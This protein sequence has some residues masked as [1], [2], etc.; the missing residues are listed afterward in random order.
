[1]TGARGLGTFPCFL[2]VQTEESS[3]GQRPAHSAQPEAGPEQLGLGPEG[4]G[5]A[6]QHPGLGAGAGL[7]G[8]SPGPGQSGLTGP[9]PG[10]EQGSISPLGSTAQCANVSAVL[11]QQHGSCPAGKAKSKQYLPNICRLLFFLAVRTLQCAQKIPQHS[12]FLISISQQSNIR[13]YDPNP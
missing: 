2:F 13:I 3:P 1:M 5:Q 7:E 12:L 8:Q 6:D 11:P 4:A 10:P 9:G